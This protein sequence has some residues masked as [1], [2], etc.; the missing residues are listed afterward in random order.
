M[1][2]R[3]PGW[4][5]P[6]FHVIGS[7]SSSSAWCAGWCAGDRG[8]CIRGDPESPGAGRDRSVGIGTWG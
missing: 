1:T 6:A 2:R 8:R 7:S 5:P 4:H 3:R